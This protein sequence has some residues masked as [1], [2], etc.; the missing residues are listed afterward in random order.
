MLA[1]RL[2]FGA[3][4]ERAYAHAFRPVDTNKSLPK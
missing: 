1:I 4:S 2:G 3:L